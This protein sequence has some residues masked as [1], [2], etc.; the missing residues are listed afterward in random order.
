[1][2]G[3]CGLV[4]VLPKSDGFRMWI[5]V[6]LAVVGGALCP[7]SICAAVCILDSLFSQSGRVYTQLL[8]WSGKIKD[9]VRERR[10]LKPSCTD[11]VR[12]RLAI[13]VGVHAQTTGPGS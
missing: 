6:N 7:V 9:L 13:I 1:M 3:E 5:S 8:P 11:A 4:R 2:C 12:F 10:V